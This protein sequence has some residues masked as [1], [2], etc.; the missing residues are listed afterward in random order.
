MSFTSSKLNQEFSAWQSGQVLANPAHEMRTNTRTELFISKLPLA[1]ALFCAVAVMI[2]AS[3]NAGPEKWASKDKNVAVAQEE[4]FNWTGLYIGGHI[5]GSWDHFDLG[6]FDTDV[7]V[8]EQLIGFVRDPIGPGDVVSF[9]TTPGVDAGSDD[10]I[11]GGGQI[12]YNFQFGH[13]VVGVEGDFSGVDHSRTNTFTD[14]ENSFFF[15]G[16]TSSFTD[17]ETSRTVESSWM[18]S[19]RGRLGWAE[20][21]VLLYVT[22]GVA[23]AEVNVK[24]FDRA[25]TTFFVPGGQGV[26]IGI[27]PNSVIISTIASR[28]I[29]H[30]DSVL[31]G[32]TGGGGIEWAPHN[33]WSIGIE[34]RHSEFGDEN[35][36]FS[37]HRGPIF[38]RNGGSTN[39]DL[40]NDQVTLRVNVMLGHIMSSH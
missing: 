8:F 12:G 31:F 28:N 17:L 20:G 4:P 1:G 14:S 37:S 39:V 29:D 25:T 40:E 30:D 7:N 6:S 32:W 19:G 16:S 36:S 33:N 2:A 15:L 11:I 35:F 21:P 3:A 23:F 13:F 34:Y 26:G 18:G 24:E 10:S 22:G 38:V 27:P 9:V 5:G